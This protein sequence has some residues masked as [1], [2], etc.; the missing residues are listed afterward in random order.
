MNKDELISK[1]KESN[2]TDEREA[3][4]YMNSFVYTTLITQ[5][6]CIVFIIKNIVSSIKTGGNEKIGALLT[7]IFLQFTLS[8]FFQFKM[9]KKKLH[10]LFFIIYF[11]C[12]VF[13]LSL[14]FDNY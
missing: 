8:E 2:E 9:S 7:L 6:L 12:T 10:I 1:I 3:K 11:I 14:Y 4:L 13:T 5:L